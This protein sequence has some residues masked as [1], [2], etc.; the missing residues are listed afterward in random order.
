MLEALEASR[1]RQT[2]LVADAGHE[3]K[4]PLTSLRTNV[5][6]LM[7]VSQSKSA[8]PPEELESLS[9]DV[10]AQIEELSTLIGD[11]VDLAR[12]DGPQ[13]IVECGDLV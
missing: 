12:E 11:L 6:L 8:I 10:I 1:V 9:R 13:Q 3:L 2:Q 4:T 7:M 5:E